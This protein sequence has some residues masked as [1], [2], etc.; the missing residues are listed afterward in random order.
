MAVEHMHPGGQKFGFNHQQRKDDG[1]LIASHSNQGCDDSVRCVTCV[2]R[3]QSSKTTIAGS[4]IW[5]IA[6]NSDLYL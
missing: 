1:N 5:H 3:D 6:S 4:S 2:T